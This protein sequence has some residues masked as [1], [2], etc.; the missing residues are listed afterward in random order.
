MKKAILRILLVIFGLNVF[1]ACYGMP[2]K[3]WTQPEPI[4][5]E[6]QKQ[7]QDDESKAEEPEQD[8]PPAI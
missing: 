6:Q 1:T 8:I 2:P 4:T 7:E 3:D 5:E